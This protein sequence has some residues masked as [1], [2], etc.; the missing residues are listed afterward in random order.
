MLSPLATN[1]LCKTHAQ[2][3]VTVLQFLFPFAKFV[4]PISN[5]VDRQN[6]LYVKIQINIIHSNKSAHI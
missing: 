1:K 2:K 6:F 4:I 3:V 5:L